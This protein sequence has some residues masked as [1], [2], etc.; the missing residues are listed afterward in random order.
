MSY[1]SRGEIDPLE[2]LR[3]RREYIKKR[4]EERIKRI[5]NPKTLQM[6][7]DQEY[8]KQQINEKKKIKRIKRKRRC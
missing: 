6:G 5:Q 8:L 1:S 4:D 3:L 7:I 2:K